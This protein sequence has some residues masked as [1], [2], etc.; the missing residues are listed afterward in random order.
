MTIIIS[1]AI[2]LS[3][4][5]ISYL[6]NPSSYMRGEFWVL[7]ILISYLSYN[8][9]RYLQGVPMQISIGTGEKSRIYQ[10]IYF[11]VSLISIILLMIVYFKFIISS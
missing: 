2:A 7:I 9:C 3:I 6:L 5:V 8:A 10:T 1:L 11:S 4:I